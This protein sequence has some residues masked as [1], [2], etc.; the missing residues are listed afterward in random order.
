MVAGASLPF[1]A[2]LFIINNVIFVEKFNESVV[3]DWVKYFTQ[4]R[5]DR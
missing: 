4:A 3:D 5:V 1:E 2:N